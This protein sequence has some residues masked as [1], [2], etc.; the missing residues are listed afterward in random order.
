M[1]K[2][3]C[4]KCKSKQVWKNRPKLGK[5][6]NNRVALTGH[7]NKCNTKMMRF[8]GKNDLQSG[9]GLVGKLLGLPG[10]KVPGLGSIPLIGA[11]F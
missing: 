4:V 6:K 3:Y 11:L 7:C 9:N 8:I 2:S 5:T 10:G 1:D